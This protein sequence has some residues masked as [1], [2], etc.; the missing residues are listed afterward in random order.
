MLTSLPH[1]RT[2][3]ARAWADRARERRNGPV[4]GPFSADRP[5]MI[6]SMTTLLLA[7]LSG[8]GFFAASLL[9]G[10]RLGASRRFHHLTVV[11]AAAVLLGVT[12][13][14]LLPETFALLD[15]TT[16][17]LSLAA[18]FLVLYLIETLTSGHTHHH[19]PHAEHAHAHSHAPTPDADGCVPRHAML[20]FLVGLG[21]HNVADGL[22][23]GTSHEVSDVAATAVATGI[24]VH[25]LPVGLSFAAVLVASGSG[26]R[27]TRLSALGIGALIPIGAGVVALVPDLGTQT[28]GILVGVAAG[29]L[30]YIAT[31]HLLPEAQ[32]EQR[33]PLLAAA[34]ATALV[35]TI[36][37]IGA[38]HGE[39][40]GHAQDDQAHEEAEH[41]EDEHGE[42]E[43]AEAEHADEPA[44]TAR[45]QQL[46]R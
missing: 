43:E 35:G 28:L 9:V 25:Q 39:E 29:A 24:L 1:A 4:S 15:V 41:E 17:A 22:V 31:G 33:R 37:L 11:V 34:F 13:G 21:L 44:S 16:A 14:E 30:I 19:E 7:L 38:A 42:D 2:S 12:L 20:P 18:G 46:A 32:S 6:D 8:A 23:I 27:R 3:L 26:A 36:L 45:L 5:G 10:T 40:H